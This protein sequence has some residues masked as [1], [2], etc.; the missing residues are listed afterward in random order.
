MNQEVYFKNIRAEI[1]T[2]LDKCESDLKI[3]VA[4]FTDKKIIKKVNELI[5]DDISVEIIIYDDHVNKKELFEQLYYGNAKIYLSKKLMHNKFCV[6][7]NK[8]VINGS[9]NW[10]LNA[11]TN[12]ENIQITYDNS[13]FAERFSTQFDNLVK[14]CKPIDDYF[15]YSLENLNNIN[16]E[17]KNYLSQHR[18][19]RYPYFYSLQ[20]LELTESNKFFKSL[21]QGYYLIKNEDEEQ[22]FLRTKYFIESKY[23]L[24][25]INKILNKKI[26]LPDFYDYIPSLKTD[27][28]T[29]FFFNQEAY[30]VETWNRHRYVF[31]IDKN[32]SLIGDK[33]PFTDKLP[34]G[35]YLQNF[36]NFGSKKYIVDIELKK[37]DL[38]MVSIE[39][40][41]EIGIFGEKKTKKYRKEYKFG[42]K[43]FTNNILVNF[44]YDH[45]EIDEGNHQV[46]FIE[47]PHFQKDLEQGKLIYLDKKLKD[48]KK[49]PYKITSYDYKRKTLTKNPEIIFPKKINRD[50][51]TF[52]TDDNEE[53]LRLYVA[54][55]NNK[56][57]FSYLKLYD[58][59]FSEFEKLKR[60]Y[61]YGYAKFKNGYSGQSFLEYQ[62]KLKQ[63][64]EQFL[65]DFKGGTSEK[66]G[67]Y[68]ATMVYGNYNH[69]NVIVLRK[70]RDYN[71]KNV[72]IGRLFIKYYY[73]FSPQYVE[74]VKNKKHLNLFSTIIIKVITHGIKTWH[75]NG[76]CC[77]SSNKSK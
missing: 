64:K 36:S 1:L 20:N 17:F 7:D 35:L 70:F 37:F 41:K 61:F 40:H 73:R 76:N 75:N 10:T 74:Y 4:W 3:A 34:N 27:L 16:W 44:K 9:Y 31:Y 67:C 26:S 45:Y 19:S 42:L 68:V 53:Y 32:G 29:T 46:N 30:P 63:Q 13:E 56:F 5:D 49:Y 69:P 66:E 77:T 62:D 50:D 39:L 22:E 60:E 72:L 43:N 59:K 28:N 38:D 54:L 21:K 51:F 33:V 24:N 14:S 18:Q 23:S 52:L 8:T 11:S 25:K 65:N 47:L 12:E 57:S 48:F 15:E 55:S 6:I 58:I 2:N 71:L